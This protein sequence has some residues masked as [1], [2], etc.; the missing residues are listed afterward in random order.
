VAAVAAATVALAGC[1]SVRNDLGTANSGCYVA[2]PAASAAVGHTGRLLGVRLFDVPSLKGT[3][4]LLYEAAVGAPGAKV[5]R[6]CLVAFTGHFDAGRVD[7][8]IG[9][10]TGHLAVVEV[11][12]PGNRLLATLLLG[13]ES[14]PFGHSHLGLF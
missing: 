3:S 6:V 7:R 12:Y 13:R 2:L 4:N 11:S 14:L 1:T 10:S 5:Q 8:P 9:A